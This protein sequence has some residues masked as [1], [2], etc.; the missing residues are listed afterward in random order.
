MA[1]TA[2]GEQIAPG[3]GQRQHDRAGESERAQQHRQRLI[4]LVAVQPD[5]QHTGHRP[6]LVPA[7]ATHGEGDDAQRLTVRRSGEILTV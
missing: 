3:G 1:A 2:A 5:L 4:E 7:L 6:R